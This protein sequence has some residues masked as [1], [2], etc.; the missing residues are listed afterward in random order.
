[1]DLITEFIVE[2]ILEGIVELIRNKNINKWI[3][4]PLLIII[5]GFYIFILVML[6]IILP[7]AFKESIYMGFT[8][9][10]LEIILITGVIYIIRS[11]LGKKDRNSNWI[12]FSLFKNI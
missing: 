4:Y 8:L 6:G 3:R 1:M 9:S 2:V 11:S 12:S 10:C 5:L 7:A